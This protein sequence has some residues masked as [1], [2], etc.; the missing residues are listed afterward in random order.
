MSAICARCSRVGYS[1]L[2]KRVDSWVIGCPSW[3]KYKREE[4]FKKKQGGIT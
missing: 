4:K 3:S 2:S 1:N